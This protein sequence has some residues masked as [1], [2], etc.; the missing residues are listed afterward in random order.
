[1]LARRTPGFTGADLA[2][3]VN[4]AALLSA[5]HSK[6]SIDMQELEE[7]IY[8]VIAGPERKSR[9]ISD[10]EKEIIAY[11]E[12]G[13]AL[14]AH[15]LPNTD[16]VHKVS[17]IP[18][19]RA[20]GYTLTLPTEDK[21]LVTRDELMDELA[22]LLG[23]RTAEELIFADPTTGAQNDIERATKVARQMVTEFGMSD[24]L[25]PLTL[26]QKQG[27]VF[28]GRDF[29]AQPD[30]SDQ[31]AYE[32]DQEIK[33]LV[34][35]AY[36]DARRILTENLDKLKVIA[37]TL[38]ERE[39]VEKEELEALLAGRELEPLVPCRPAGP[40]GKAGQTPPTLPHQG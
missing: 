36:N 38:I 10:K 33:R 19:G 23:G 6:K 7:A 1:M 3:L 39:T 20:L 22:M 34:D 37:A 5:R 16:P 24:R 12:G 40:R 9:L 30:Y 15:A 21:F 4:E 13:H 8:R 27:E 25:G 31:I 14:V 29:A 28:L 2:N 32:I 35:D 26:G 17:I 18:R 11:H